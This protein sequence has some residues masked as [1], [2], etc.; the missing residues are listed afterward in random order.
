ML[1]VID[2]HLPVR[3]P[4]PIYP[5]MQRPWPEAIYKIAE[6][7]V[8]ARLVDQVAQV[9]VSQSF[10]NTGSRPLEV[11]FVFP[12]PYDGAIEQMTLLVDG[13]EYPA[14]LLG[15]EE[16]RRTYEEIVR[17][18]R[19]PALL[20]WIGTGMF[21]TNV[22]PVPAGATRTVSLRYAQLC[23]KA[24][25][26]TDFLFPLSTAKY[27]SQPIQRVEFRVSIEAGEEIKNVYS[28]THAVEIQRSDDRHATIT[29]RANDCVPNSD[30]RLLYD[31]GQGKVAARVLS[32]RPNGS[33]DG[34]FLLLACPQIKAAAEQPPRKTVVFVMDR[35][36]SMTGKKIEQV[37]RGLRFMLDRLRPGDLFNIIVYD[38]QVESFQPELQ[39]FN[40]QTRKAAE[41]FVEGVYA[42]GS[43]DINAALRTAFA[44]LKDAATP[45]YIIFLTD[46]MPTTGVT[47]EAQIVAN[48]KE[49]NRARARIFAFGVGDDVN[50]RLLD[51]LV[52][53]SFGQSEY[54]GTE[55]DIEDHISRLYRRIESPVMTDVKIEFTL[56][57]KGA[58]EGR[59][60]NRVYPHGSFDLFAGE[61]LVT[62]GR[63]RTPGAAKVTVSGMVDGK[64]QALDFPAELV[65]KSPDETRGFVEKLWAVRRVG[66]ILDEIDLHGRNEELIQELVDLST[67]HAI[68]TPYTSFL[69]DENTRLGDVTANTRRAAG[70]LLALDQVSGYGGVQQRAYKGVMQRANQPLDGYGG[71][72]VFDAEPRSSVTSA[73][74]AGS[75]ASVAAVA[76]PA[77]AGPASAP[78]VTGTLGVF[79]RQTQTNPAQRGEETVRNVGNRAF[80]RRGGQW[81]DS[82]LSEAQQTQAKRIK[83]FSDAYFE[84]ARRN[85][86]QLAQ[87][88][89][90]DEPVVLNVEGQAYL[91]EP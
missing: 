87:Y 63:Y 21:R 10:V 68:L 17:K 62:V 3:L 35:S 32:Y 73:G 72:A 46:G 28:P 6:L 54:V 38:S 66:E 45:S 82:Q 27:T 88:M 7:E 48:A 19:D 36:G 16:A 26:L 2:P 61:Q 5:P 58:E 29:Y 49:A 42:G 34:Y 81:I 47:N 69:A 50:A 15:A 33:D 25:G 41:G 53:G 64:R 71:H 20:E 76:S 89:V 90:F 65:E 74:M 14:R 13:R 44:Q 51:R 39:R 31:V 84:L 18:N 67:R 60:V 43:T 59:G 77:A 56:D 80:Y 78:A 55:E 40:D 37:R 57:A 70:N 8:H 23:R 4:R 24:D 11:A 85:G 83:Q 9:Q 91:I 12:L 75:A 79:G 30:F 52:R 86:R 22:F 1:I